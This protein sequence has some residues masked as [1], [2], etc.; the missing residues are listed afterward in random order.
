MTARIPI[1]TNADDRYVNDKFQAMPKD[2]YNKIF[3]NMLKGIEVRLNT[4]FKEVKNKVKYRKLVY[5]GPI[6]EFFDYK[7][8]KLPYRSL[9]FQI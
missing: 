8:G 9:K 5:T 2:G 4:E 3:E 1:R 6:D 7:Y